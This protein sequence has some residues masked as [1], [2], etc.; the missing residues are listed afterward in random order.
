MT[1]N[2]RSALPLPLW[3]L[4]HASALL[5]AFSDGVWLLRCSNLQSI[6][7]LNRTA[8]TLMLVVWWGSVECPSLRSRFVG[9]VVHQ[10]SPQK[11]EPRLCYKIAHIHFSWACWHCVFICATILSSFFL[12]WNKH[13]AT[14]VIERGKLERQMCQQQ[15]TLFTFNITTAGSMSAFRCYESVATLCCSWHLHNPTVSM[16]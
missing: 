11:S 5:G 4:Q 16:K 10:N 3:H 6:P 15:L 9:F 13:G 12:E 7:M 14:Q 8:S 2:N 1:F